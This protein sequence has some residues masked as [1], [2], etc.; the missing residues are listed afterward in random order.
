MGREARLSKG[1]IPLYNR[2]K[3][4]ALAT[5]TFA[6]DLVISDLVLK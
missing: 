4:P 5:A 3:F 1:A 2:E 6:T